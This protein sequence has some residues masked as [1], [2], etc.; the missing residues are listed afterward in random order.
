M[1]EASIMESLLTKEILIAA[2]AILVL[3]TAFR[4][5][6]PRFEKNQIWRRLLPF[7]PLALGVASA[8]IMTTDAPGIGDKILIGLW[9]GGVATGARKVFNQTL[10][11][12][13]SE[14]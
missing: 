14:K 12:Q 6:F 8:F 3:I 11:G 2:G 13:V 4:I 5:A 9:T 7:I 1:I 10:R